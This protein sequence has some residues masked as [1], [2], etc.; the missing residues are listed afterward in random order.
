MPRP[1]GA[2]RNYLFPEKPC[3][4]VKKQPLVLQL[5][6]VLIDCLTQGEQLPQ[7]F[8]IGSWIFAKMPSRYIDEI[9]NANTD[10]QL[11]FLNVL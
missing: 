3:D 11:L 2:G 5:V 8:G 6:E 1:R 7:T 9:G 4:R 10:A